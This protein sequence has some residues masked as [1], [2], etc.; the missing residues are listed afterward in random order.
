[1]KLKVDGKEYEVDVDPDTPL[2]WVLRD[3]LNK[4][5]PKFGCGMA[6]CGACTVHLDGAAIRSCIMPASAITGEVTTIEGLGN[7]DELHPVQQAWLAEQVAQCGYCQGG[8]MMSAAALLAE[9]PKPS[10]AEIDAAM[11]GN[12]CRCATYPR[13]RKAIHKASDLAAKES[14]E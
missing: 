7:S 11:A 14:S 12:L 8:Q 13:I 2:L 1:M 6:Q 4:K 10:D 9:K 3:Q 5:G